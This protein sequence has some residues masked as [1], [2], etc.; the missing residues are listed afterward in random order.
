MGGHFRDVNKFYGSM[1]GAAGLLAARAWAMSARVLGLLPAAAGP[2]DGLSPCPL[3]ERETCTG[4][5][6]GLPEKG[7][8][9]CSGPAAG[10]GPD[11]GRGK[12]EGLE[13]KPV[14][15]FL[16]ILIISSHVFNFL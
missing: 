5:V 1:P 9:A 10:A 14:W 4:M 12:P 2:L 16:Y 11:S 3:M 6:R 7:P 15:V 13:P 8:A